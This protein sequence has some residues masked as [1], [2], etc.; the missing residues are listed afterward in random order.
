MVGEKILIVEDESVVAL[1]I[2]M[3][4]EA[5]QYRVA[6]VA[7]SAQTALAIVA[8]A[9][10]DLVLMDIRLKGDQNG[11]KTAQK[12]QEQ[13][14]VPIVYLTAY[15][16]ARVLQ[17]AQQT[18][19]Y[20]YVLKPFDPTSLC[21]TIE[22][23]LK[24]HRSRTRLQKLN[25]ELEQRVQEHLRELE[26][27]NQQL[28][29]EKINRQPAETARSK[30]SNEEQELSDLK[31]RFITTA[32]HEF[33]TPLAIVMTS[34]EL[35]ER[36]G[37]QCSEE[38]RVTYIQKIRDAVRSMTR[39]LTDMMTIGKAKSNQ[40]EFNPTRLELR[41]FC[42]ALLTDLHL[43]STSSPAISFEVVGEC[44]EACLDAEML[45][46]MLTNLLSNA[47]KYSPK[48]TQIELEL[49]CSSTATEP[50]FVVFCIQDHGIGIPPEDLPRI[51]E[52]FHR[53]KN[54]ETIAGAGLGLTIVEQCVAY[55]RGEIRVES[56]LN[57]GTVVMVRLPVGIEDCGR[58]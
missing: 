39:I 4:L 23:A 46:L 16:D 14:D 27:V 26:R 15:T 58:C 35:I 10:P 47:V 6:G 8:A 40:L 42:S 3:R 25:A 50:Q 5:A 56:V 57:Q 36:L 2:Q 7:D 20:G 11:L 29:T 45:T 48:H 30:A 18:Q 37:A 51:F 49:N 13:C 44:A 33:R 38:R 12:I 1:S 28:Q 43:S 55:H 19:P 24:N 54:V 53:A 17:Q 41:S 21:S 22:I 31:S 32:S 34:A 9:A 52:P